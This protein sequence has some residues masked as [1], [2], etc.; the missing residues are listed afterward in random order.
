M[1]NLIKTLL[2]IIGLWWFFT[3]PNAKPAR[4][5]LGLAIIGS[6]IVFIIALALLKIFYPGAF[7]E[8]SRVNGW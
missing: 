4:N 1:G 7:M 8:T 3:C 5:Y 2:W 6:W